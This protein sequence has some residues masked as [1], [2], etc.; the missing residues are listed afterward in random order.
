MTCRAAAACRR[1]C[2][3]RIPPDSLEDTMAIG[4]IARGDLVVV[5]SDKFNLR[6]LF[7]VDSVNGNLISLFKAEDANLKAGGTKAN[8]TIVDK[9]TDI[10][11]VH[12]ASSISV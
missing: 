2:G 1:A 11:A 4:A 10:V 12:T 3:E 7:V 5:H 9:T 6:G 8:V